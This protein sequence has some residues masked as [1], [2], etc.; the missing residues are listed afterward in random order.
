VDVSALR[1]FAQLIG[2]LDTRPKP[3]AT[4]KRPGQSLN[5]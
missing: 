1:T 2:T 3:N 4:N 5:E